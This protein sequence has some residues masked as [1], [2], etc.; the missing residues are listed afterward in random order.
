MYLNRQGPV[1]H[2]NDSPTLDETIN[3]SVRATVLEFV[4]C[5]E[6][7]S[8]PHRKELYRIFGRHLVFSNYDTNN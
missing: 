2:E 7:T 4:I 1:I 5:D 8:R 3:L 6:N